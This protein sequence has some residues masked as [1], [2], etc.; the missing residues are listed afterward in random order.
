MNGQREGGEKDKQ[1][2]GD[3]GCGREA[4]GETYAQIEREENQFS[5]LP[6]TTV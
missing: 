4:G 3:K 5:V 6:L 1:D 2:K